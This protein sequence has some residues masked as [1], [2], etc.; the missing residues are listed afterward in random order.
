MLPKRSRKPNSQRAYF[1]LQESELLS[2]NPI[3]FKSLK[4]AVKIVLFIFVLLERMIL[5][6][7]FPSD[8]SNL[9]SLHIVNDI[10]IHIPCFSLGFPS[11]NP[12]QFLSLSL[13][14]CTRLYQDHDK[15]KSSMRQF[16]QAVIK[17]KQSKQASVV[18]RR[19]YK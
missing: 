16:E 3:Q 9:G 13:L 4:L 7:F 11:S 1:F 10:T 6:F 17:Q 19:K 8:E 5:F 15:Q 2:A 14:Q 12:R 18:E